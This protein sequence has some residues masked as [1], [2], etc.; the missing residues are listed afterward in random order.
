MLLTVQWC[1][2]HNSSKA[3]ATTYLQHDVEGQQS[4]HNEFVFVKKAPACVAEHHVCA[5]IQQ[6]LQANLQ[7]TSLVSVTSTERVDS[8]DAAGTMLGLS[9]QL[10]SPKTDSVQLSTAVYVLCMSIISFTSS[11][12]GVGATSS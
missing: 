2:K 10:S 8:P 7:Q 11:C 4:E 9:V 12:S 6:S 3:K 5:G 1:S